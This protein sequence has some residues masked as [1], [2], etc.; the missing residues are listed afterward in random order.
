VN[1]DSRLKD[2]Y[3]IWP[4]VRPAQNQYAFARKVF[5]LPSEPIKAEVLV[6]ADSRYRMFVNGRFVCRGPARCYPEHQAYDEIDLAPYLRRGKNC[7]A[8]LA[9][10]FGCDTL[11]SVCSNRA[12][13]LLAGQAICRRGRRVKLSTGSDW[14]IVEASAFNP[15]VARLSVQLG[16][17]EDFDAARAPGDWTSP[18]FDDSDWPTPAMLVKPGLPPWL[19]MEPSGL[20]FR[21]EEPE[22]FRRVVSVLAG[23]SAKDYAA[24]ENLGLLAFSEPRKRLSRP[25]QVVTDIDALLRPGEQSTVIEPTGR[26][27]FTALLLDAG[28]EVAA[29]ATLDITAAGGEIIDFIYS[30]H[31]TPAGDILLK[32][33][34]TASRISMADRYRAKPGRQQHEFFWWKGFRYLLVVF[35]NLAKPLK[36][37]HIGMKFT[38]YP[39]QMAGD[40]DCSDDRLNQIWSTGRYTLQLCMHDAY[41]DCP[42]REQAQWMGDARVEAAVTAYTFADCRLLK[43]ILRQCAQSQSPCGLTYGVFPSRAH[44]NILPD[45]CLVWISALWDYFVLT[46]DDEPLREHYRQMAKVLEWFE[47]SC[48]RGVLPPNPG[49]GLWLFIDWSPLY[50]EDLNAT[51]A[52]Q[53]LEALRHASLIARKIGR[54]A[55]ARKFA[56]RADRVA[57]AI[58]KTFWDPARGAFC[59]GF[60]RSK[61]RRVRQIGQHANSY[62]ILLGLKSQHHNRIARRVLWPISRDHDRLLPRNA[63]GNTYRKEATRP[64]ASPYFY[65]YVLEAMFRTDL[66]KQAVDTILRLWYRM[67]EQGFTTFYETWDHPQT[68]GFSSAC[69]AWSAG[70]TY[71]LSKYIGGVA[72]AAPGWR[73]VRIDPRPV[74]LYYAS[75]V[76]PTPYGQIRCRWE[77]LARNKL[78]LEVQ[79]PEPIRAEVPASE[80]RKRIGPGSHRLILTR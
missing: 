68:P 58:E 14:R 44:S 64:I 61:N 70:P 77:R 3:W 20:P 57:R 23:R 74:H 27:R 7:I 39:V 40:F 38:S 30:E 60:D 18:D 19:Q 43:R 65:F 16:F 21:L 76:V 63:G 31:M 41:V 52:M 4:T 17:Q 67:I 53:Y 29:Y 5:D 72:L 59:E 73:R 2:A 8:I 22:N 51:Y 15:K 71:H 66:Q 33:P 1:A 62:A 47:N 11:Q 28:R 46:G 35:R 32:D 13:I 50:K 6:T 55:D 42:W 69:H 75:T 36:V 34:T 78:S 49:P 9:F 56:E 25:E 12:G 37:H 48:G 24:A 10:H 45:Y 26:D 79:L 80:G 54:P